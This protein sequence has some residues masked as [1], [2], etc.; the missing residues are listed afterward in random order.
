MPTITSRVLL[1]AVTVVVAVLSLPDRA[2]AAGGEVIVIEGQRPRPHV[3]PRVKNH[4]RVATPPYSQTA[5]ER[6][7]W[8]RA[9]LLLDVDEAG[10]VTRFKFINRPGHDLEGI[11]AHKAFSLRFDPARDSA[12][13]PIKS[14]VIWGIEWP[15]YW[16]LV[17]MGQP[18]TRMPPFILT[19]RGPRRLDSGVPCRGSGPLR[20]DSIHPVYKDCSLPDL[21]RPFDAEPWINRV[22]RPRSPL[23]ASVAPTPR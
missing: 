23:P 8:A 20:L 13:H 22:A 6:D 12:N 3:P 4:D 2:S 10:R 9:W 15:S 1:L 5:I 11:A 17:A 19:P 21:K 18:T 16:W 7:A 14:W